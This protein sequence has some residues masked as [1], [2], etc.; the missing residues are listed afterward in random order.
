MSGESDGS[1]AAEA[2]VVDEQGQ[3]FAGAA[4]ER[5][6]VG[7]GKE[8][9]KARGKKGK[10]AR[11]KGRKVRREFSAGFILFREDAAAPGGIAYLLLDYGKHWDYAKGH[12]EE[13]ET[14]WQ[15]A[16]RELREETGIRQVDRVTRFE[17][18]MQYVF[19]SPKKGQVHK[20]VTYFLGRT[21]AAAVKVSEE[22]EGYAWLGYE[23]ALERLTYENAREML[24]AAHEA[25]MK[26]RSAGGN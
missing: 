16:V 14:A 26:G 9:K 20:T 12:L 11:G 15:A 17:R 10:G 19:Y 21:R 25:L 23:E 5:G 1:A 6:E 2:T 3:L 4:R 24:R 8:S 7:G 18:D 22:H 13:G